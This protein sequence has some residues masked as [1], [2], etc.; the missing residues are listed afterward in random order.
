MFGL[1]AGFFVCYGTVN[2]ESSLSW[3]LPFLLQTAISVVFTVS[4]L[5]FAPHSPRW[6]SAYG[7]HKEA[8]Q[9]WG[10]LGVGA[11][12][13]EKTESEIEGDSKPV[14][15]RDVLAVF[16]RGARTQTAIGVFLMGMQ[17]LSGI[18]GVLYVWLRIASEANSTILT[19]MYS[20]RLCYSK[21]RV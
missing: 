19:D 18:D 4:T 10:E 7:R 17:Q 9:V 2:I 13:R 11:A 20:T 15:I 1:C 14:H 3:R 21:L 16:G 5:M 6:L 8:L 12:E